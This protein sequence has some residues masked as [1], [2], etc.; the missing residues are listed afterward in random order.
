MTDA[1]HARTLLF[2]TVPEGTEF[3]PETAFAASAARRLGLT[4]QI[5]ATD[6]C[7]TEA[8]FQSA[9][10]S[11]AAYGVVFA[12]AAEHRE[13]IQGLAAFALRAGAERVVVIGASLAE[14]PPPDFGPG[15]RLV[16]STRPSALA[17]ALDLPAPADDSLATLPLDV[18]VYGGPAL[19]DRA[20]G[21]SLFGET[22]VAA[23]IGVRGPRR[24][25]SPTAA[26]A[27][28]E[29]ALEDGRR[30]LLLPAVA[31]HPLE[32]LGAG[33]KRVEWLDRDFFEASLLHPPWP[34]AEAADRAY[35]EPLRRRGLFQSVR[36]RAN[37]PSPMMETL[38]DL[39]VGRVVF[40][41]D[42]LEDAERLPGARA[43]ATDVAA[44]IETA[45]ALGLESGVLLTVGLP[46]ETAAITAERCARL[47]SAGVA[48]V[49]VTPF[50]PTGG[51]AAAWC[52]RRGLWPPLDQRWNREL[53]QP[54]RQPAL[55]PDAFVRL[56]EVA[57]AFAAE[58]AVRA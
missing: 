36:V 45:R 23:L 3:A 2:A 52:E 4:P 56:Y 17:A 49:R 57:L 14:D 50:E 54:L 8:G 31:F 40:D 58:T 10:A 51:A 11:A 29:G 26:L 41:C 18:D 12:D 35:L 7:T 16:R 21:C 24:E 27:R 22:D 5:I 33:V 20:L 46:G 42:A 38:R 34:G 37:I 1:A 32:R 28:L 39:G 30:E 19:L 47:R 25:S 15:V 48:R 55:G 53:F 9:V 6:F 13:V 43:T 44:G